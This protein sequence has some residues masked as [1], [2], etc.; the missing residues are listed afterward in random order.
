MTQD[1]PPGVVRGSAPSAPRYVVTEQGPDARQ[2]LRRRR[3]ASAPSCSDGAKGSSKK[4]PSGPRPRPRSSPSRPAG[5]T[6]RVPELPEVETVRSA[7]SRDLVGKKIKSPSTVTRPAAPFVASDRASSRA[8]SKVAGSIASRACGKNLLVELDNGEHLVV[9]L[10]HERASC[11]TRRSEGPKAPA[12]PRGDH[13]HPGRRT[14]LRRPADL[15]RALRLARRPRPRQIAASDGGDG[16]ALRR[17][18]A[19]AGDCR[20]SSRTDRLGSLRGVRHST[21]K[22]LLTRPGDRSPASATSTPTRSCFAA[23]L[24]SDRASESLGTDEIRR[25]TAAITEILT[26]AVKHG[27]STLADEQLPWTCSASPGPTRSEQRL[28]PR[29][30]AL[31]GAASRSCAT[32]FAGRSTFCCPHCQS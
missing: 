16:L 17:A 32:R 24:R 26:E 4:R 23:G 18:D 10:R 6:D 21:L 7:L 30:R 20:R 19:R 28:R 11:A 12:H 8:A 25:L 31:P 14:A 9:H 2:A 27:G 1:P 13:L 5:A 29:G 3:S 22:A 15:R